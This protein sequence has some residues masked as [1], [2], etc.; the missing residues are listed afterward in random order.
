MQ[1]WCGKMVGLHI[2][3][4]KNYHSNTSDSIPRHGIGLE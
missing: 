2:V 1:F 4:E 3:I